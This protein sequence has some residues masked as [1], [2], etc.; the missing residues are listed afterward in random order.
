MSI[1]YILQSHESPREVAILGISDLSSKSHLSTV[2]TSESGELLF[3][4][5]EWLAERDNTLYVVL[6][7]D[8]LHVSLSVHAFTAKDKGFGRLVAG[9]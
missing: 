8:N 5:K 1:D 9:D 6:T 7:G 2:T 4:K 3:V